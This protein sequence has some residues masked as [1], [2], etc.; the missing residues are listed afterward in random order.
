MFIAL[1][2][3]EPL[4]KEKFGDSKMLEALRDYCQVELPMFRR[5]NDICELR[6]VEK[7]HQPMKSEF[8]FAC[9][10]SLWWQMRGRMQSPGD[11]CGVGWD[12]ST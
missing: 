11:W 3:Q 9:T 5:P 7:K 10:V 12:Y 8:M 1:V 4:L 6:I 2:E